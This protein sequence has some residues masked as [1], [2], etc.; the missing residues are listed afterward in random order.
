[1][2]VYLPFRAFHYYVVSCLPLVL[3]SGTLWAGLGALRD[4]LP[5]RPALSCVSVACVLSIAFSRIVVDTIVPI[6]IARYRSYD[7]AADRSYFDELV[8]REVIDFG[9]PPGPRPD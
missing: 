3:L 1:M 4:K 6:A 7:A 9:V 8:S 2:L 5:P